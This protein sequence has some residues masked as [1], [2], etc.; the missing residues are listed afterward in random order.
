MGRLI[1]VFPSNPCQSQVLTLGGA[2]Y[3][4][5][6]TWRERLAG[7]YADLWDA[8]DEQVWAGVRVCSSWALGFG[9]S[10]ENRPDGIFLVRGP[11][12]ARR[13]DLG[14]SQRLAF[15]GTDELPEIVEDDLGLVVTVA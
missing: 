3:R 12:E 1:N 14:V 8:E 4:L 13:Q 2:Q 10:P 11:T 5:R 15:Y 9:L 7:W 6:L